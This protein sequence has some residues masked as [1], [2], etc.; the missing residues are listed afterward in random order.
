L[1]QN[2]PFSKLEAMNS[3]MHYFQKLT[4]FSQ[5]IHALG[6]AALNTNGFLWTDTGVCHQAE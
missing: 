3:W 6:V 5:G 1:E 2:E 4:H